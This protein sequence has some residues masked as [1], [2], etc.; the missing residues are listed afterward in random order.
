ML[1]RDGR[2]VGFAVET[3]AGGS[4]VIPGLDEVVHSRTQVPTLVA[5]PFGTMQT[6]PRVQIKRLMLD[7]PS[8]IVACGLAMRRFDPV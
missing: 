2:R 4:A 8:L 3:L 5:N 1:R 6:S 7:A